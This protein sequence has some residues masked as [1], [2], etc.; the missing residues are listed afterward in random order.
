MNAMHIPPILRAISFEP[1]TLEGGTV[2]QVP[3]ATPSFPLWKGVP[4]S[5]SYGGKPVLEHAGTPLFAELVI[6]RHLQASGWIGAWI[7]TYRSRVLTDLDTP[8]ELPRERRLLLDRIFEFAGS[9]HGCFDVFAWHGSQILFAEAKR[10]RHDRIRN[11]QIRWLS[12]A[13]RSGVSDS[14]FL[15]VEWSAA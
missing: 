8:I 13:R 15:V 7:D 4:L 3:K 5:D 1:F 2:V 14:S 12:A 9:R 10:A 6:L 11:S